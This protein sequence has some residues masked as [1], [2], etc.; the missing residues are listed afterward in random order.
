MQ[1]E[2]CTTQPILCNVQLVMCVWLLFYVVKCKGKVLPQ[3]IINLHRE[4]GVN[5]RCIVDVSNALLDIG[6]LI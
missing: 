3:Y 4:R 6:N 1:W 5:V 2:G